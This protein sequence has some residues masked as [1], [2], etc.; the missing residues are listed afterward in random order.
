MEQTRANREVISAEAVREQTDRILASVHF[1]RS[2]A[3]TRFLR[4]VVDHTLDGK[5]LEIKEYR[6]GVDVFDRG[7]EFDPRIDPIVRIQAAKLRSR[8]AE[9][10]SDRG[11]G[12]T[13][14][15]TIGKGAYVPSFA[16]AQ[17]APEPVRGTP[18]AQSIA[19]LPFVNISA[20]PE[21]EYFSDGLTEELISRF[22]MI[23]GLRVVSRTSVFGFKN[24]SKDI[25]EIGAQLNAHSVLEGSVRRIGNQLRVTAQLVEVSTGYHLMSRTYVREL[26]DV[27]AAQDELAQAI[28]SEV[29]PSVLRPESRPRMPFLVGQPMP[30]RMISFQ[31]H[32]SARAS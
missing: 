2:Q 11:H 15:I 13:V 14:V 10:Y 31:D 19:V 9:Y 26:K 28:I 23:P 20:N 8:L 6:L 3:L 12:D 4:F 17:K 24:A 27:F 7:Q 5:E 30:G 16:L 29:L 22:T 1:A 21:N 18:D 25:R 32:L